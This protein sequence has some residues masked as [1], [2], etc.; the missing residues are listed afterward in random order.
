MLEI[1]ALI[2]LTRKIGSMAEAKGHSGGTYKFFTVLLWF[3]GE[4]VGFIIGSDMYK[5]S[6]ADGFNLA[7]YGIALIGAAAGALAAYLLASNLP[8]KNASAT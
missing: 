1:L 5:S 8:D 3:G 4:V 6:D 2:A 7:A